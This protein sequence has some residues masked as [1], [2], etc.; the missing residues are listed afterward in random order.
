MEPLR[1]VDMAQ[2]P[3]E[4]AENMMPNVDSAPKYPY[5]LSIRLTQDELDKMNVDHTDWQI[6]DMFHLHAMGKVTSISEHETEGGQRCC[7][8]IQ[9]THLA[10]ESED[11]E[12]EEE[13]K[14]EEGEDSK[15]EDGEE[16]EPVR[17][18]RNMYF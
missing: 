16:A 12:N 3:A 14:E 1:M 13:E 6:G 9:L 11:A 15:G 5:G 18:K 17:K 8:E 7:V 4:A 2:T 10:G